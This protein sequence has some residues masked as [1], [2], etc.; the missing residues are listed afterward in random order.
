MNRVI[1]ALTLGLCSAIPLEASADET[2][3]PAE[4]AEP[5]ADETCLQCHDAQ[6]GSASADDAE[7]GVEMSAYHDSIHGDL[8]CVE[9]HTEAEDDSCRS[10]LDPV[11]CG[12][13]HATEEAKLGGGVHGMAFL[14]E[15]MPVTCTDCH[16]THD[17]LAKDDPASRVYPTEL[18][19]TCGQCHDSEEHDLPKRAPGVT[20]EDYVESAHYTG[21]TDDGLLKS[22]SCIGCHGNHGMLA[23][24]DPQSLVHHDNIPATCGSCH[25]GAFDDYM[26]GAHGQALAEGNDDTPVCTDCHAEHAI[27]DHEDPRATVYASKVSKSTCAQCHSGGRINR[28]YGIEEGQVETYRDTFHGLADQ[29]DG[30]EDMANCADCHGAHLILAASNPQ[31]SI[32]EDNLPATCAECHPGAGPGFAEGSVHRPEESAGGFWFGVVNNFYLIVIAFTL[33]GMLLHN[34]LDYYAHIR[35]RQRLGRRQRRYVRFNKNERL[36]HAALVISF[37]V[38]AVTGFALKYPQSF[39]VQWLLDSPVA[40]LARSIAHRVAAVVFVALSIYHVWYLIATRRGRFQMKAMLPTREDL[41]NVKHQLAY[42]LG[43]REHPAKFGRF[44][45]GEKVEYL[46]LVWGSII[47][48]I[49]GFILWFEVEAIGWMPK[50]GWDLSELIHL[51]EAWLATASIVIWHLYHV[52]FRP[53]GGGVS[54]AMFTGEITEEEMKHEHAG[55][56]EQLHADPSS[57]DAAPVLHPGEGQDAPASTEGPVPTAPSGAGKA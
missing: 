9:C 40:F 23:T 6:Q 33:G 31:S 43:L 15:G 37:V 51:Y 21:L 22:A 1:V 7:L 24:N 53:S 29:F 2:A 16:G 46:A 13:C 34:L 56:L 35:V 54:F 10:G 18:P 57:P 49:T 48:V 5:T 52:V 32:H 36:Q 45:Y 47:M 27:F 25:E 14:T 42:Y 17:T 55:E 20:V 12:D 44:T 39:W 8:A 19:T 38:L 28:R 50:W 26:T 30:T 3:E 11:D 41:R 4:T